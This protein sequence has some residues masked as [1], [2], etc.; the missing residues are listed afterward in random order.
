MSD[1]LEIYFDKIKDNPPLSD[2]EELDLFSKLKKGDK[3]A[4]E[5]IVDANVRFVVSVAK[6]YENQGLPLNDLIEEGNVGLLKATERFDPTKKF[7]FI[8]YAVWWIRQAILMALAE[9]SRVV[10]IPLHTVS[11]IQKSRNL[12][13]NLEQSR[14]QAVSHDEI[15]FALTE[16]TGKSKSSY[17]DFHM[18]TNP[19]VYLDSPTG[20]DDGRTLLDMMASPMTEDPFSLEASEKILRELGDRDRAIV[21]MYFGIPCDLLPEGLQGVSHN[22]KQIGDHFNLSRERI[23]QLLE[24]SLEELKRRILTKGTAY[25]Y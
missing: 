13:A 19:A 12:H 22:L 6:N 10:R 4:L 17:K 20:E 9:H 24:R 25:G 11:D 1:C 21:S 14:G 5:R 2:Q 23:R 18:I 8:S 3:K 16:N 15:M 7:R